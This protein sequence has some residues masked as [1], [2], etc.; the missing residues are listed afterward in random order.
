MILT[1]SVACLRS[2]LP[3][4]PGLGAVPCLPACAAVLGLYAAGPWS[5][6][7]S[8]LPL[9][10][11]LILSPGLALGLI[12]TLVLT[13]ALGLILVLSLSLTLGLVLALLS[14]TSLLPLTLPLAL[15]LPLAASVHKLPGVVS[16]SG[17]VVG[18][19]LGGDIF[20]G[21]QRHGTGQHRRETYGIHPSFHPVTPPFP[22]IGHHTYP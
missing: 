11:A 8:A 3:A 4:V 9:E 19:R 7:S 10:L 20:A 15:E 14:L 6:A 17:A 1:R 12:L 22:Q 2:R 5:S 18:D 16:R 21:G 13:L